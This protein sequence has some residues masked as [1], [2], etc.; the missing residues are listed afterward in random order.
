MVIATVVMNC[1]FVISCRS[2]ALE[3][4]RLSCVAG[5]MPLTDEIRA[6]IER[7]EDEMAELKAYVKHNIAHPKE[8]A[9]ALSALRQL[10]VRLKQLS[11]NLSRAA[12]Q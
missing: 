1:L 4:E 8:V 10:N 9:V 11:D 7:V 6:E 2:L 12:E 5:A 3:P